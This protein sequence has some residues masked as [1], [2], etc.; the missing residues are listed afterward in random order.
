MSRGRG[1]TIAEIDCLLEI[2][3]DILPIGPIKNVWYGCEKKKDGMVMPR[4][5]REYKNVLRWY[6]DHKKP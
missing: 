1:Y 2:I 4:G 5:D 6:H 3:E